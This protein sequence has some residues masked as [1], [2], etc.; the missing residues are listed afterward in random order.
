[1]AEPF[2]FSAAWD[3]WKLEMSFESGYVES[4]ERRALGEASE[5]GEARRSCIRAFFLL[6]WRI[7]PR[8]GEASQTLGAG[9]IL[10]RHGPTGRLRRLSQEGHVLM[11]SS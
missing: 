1:M 10:M 3:W 4:G 11:P 7:G 9:V 8:A 6:S 2:W 5:E